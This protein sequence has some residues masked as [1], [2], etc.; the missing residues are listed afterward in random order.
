MR[1]RQELA[2]SQR[3]K[4]AIAQTAEAPASH[5]AA[6]ALL[7]RD[8]AAAE[9]ADLLVLPELALC[10][11]SDPERIRRLASSLES[12]FIEAVRAEARRAGIGL[13]TGYAERD[14]DSLFNCALAVGPDGG[15]RANYR[16]VH[17]WGPL[18]RSLFT[19]GTPA[20]VLSWGSFRLGLL[21]C[22][23]LEF[24]EA[25][26]HQAL[27]GAEAL[28]VISATGGPYRIVPEALVPARGYE[29][30]CHV[31]FANRVGADGP[32]TF[33]GRSRIV[34]AAGEVLAAAPEDTPAIIAATLDMATL[35]DWR[36][37]HDYLADRRPEVFGWD[38][39]PGGA[40]R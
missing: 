19:P 34:T 23:D 13:I 24:P 21:I 14:G 33:L 3:L 5:E 11:Y 2:M 35:R 40:Q 38:A 37:E 32:F 22:Y 1:A 7:R 18:E 29:T 16:K 9:G 31:V 26:R 8:L 36:R 10:G 25:A 28:I 17:L 27:Q 6:L 20:P 12:P 15:L 4:I 39:P 30:G